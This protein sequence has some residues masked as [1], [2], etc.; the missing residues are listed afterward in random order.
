MVGNVWEMTSETFKVRSLKKAVAAAHAGKKGY[1]LSKGGSFLCH[2]SY[3]YRYRIAAR[4]STSP[5]T[6]T[7]HIG[8]R[9]VYDTNRDQTDTQTI[10][11]AAGRMSVNPKSE[12]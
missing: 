12:R 4:N 8:F 11:T 3:C 2:S 5:D 10:A 7:S 1:K 9:L 6:L